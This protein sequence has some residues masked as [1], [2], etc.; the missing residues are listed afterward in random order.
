LIAIPVG[1]LWAMREKRLWGNVAGMTTATLLAFPEVLW[2]LLFLLLAVETG[3]F[4]VG[5]MRTVGGGELALHEQWL[6]IGRHMVLPVLALSLTRLGAVVRHVRA[7]VA[8]VHD[9]PLI[10]ALR[11]MGTPEYRL[12]LRHTLRLAANPLITLFGLSIASL[13]SG[14]LIV[15]VVMGW[16]GLGPLLLEAILARD[17]H[18]VI[19]GVMCSALLLA[20]GGAV[21]DL[22]LYFNDPRLAFD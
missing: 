17:V 22:L 11:A 14:S 4:P 13:L 2:A 21:T 9:L 6:D 12:V 5:G 7:A 18:V 8:E 19:G 15:E 20:A 3:A 10:R 16:P 1:T